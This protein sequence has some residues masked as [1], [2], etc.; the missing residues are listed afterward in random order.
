MLIKLLEIFINFPIDE[1][2]IHYYKQD[3]EVFLLFLIVIFFI[4]TCFILFIFIRKKT[5]EN[6]NFKRNSF[7]IFMVT[8]FCL[9][10]FFFN[11]IEKKMNSNIEMCKEGILKQY[12]EM[13]TI[14]DSKLDDERI[15][16]KYYINSYT[17]DAYFQI[18]FIILGAIFYKTL[19]LIAF[20]FRNNFFIPVILVLFSNFLFFVT[21]FLLYLY[22]ANFYFKGELRSDLK[23]VINAGLQ[24][25]YVFF[26]LF[27]IFSIIYFI[28]FVLPKFSESCTLFQQALLNNKG[29]E[30]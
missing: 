2:V 7:V 22:Y 27:F 20:L 1:T 23:I 17:P 18:L 11:S 25:M 16:Q 29:A 3:L 30:I 12:K 9:V 6:E 5:V 10:L 19:K 26:E 8:T 15:L 14:D 13:Q 24:M 4:D 28:F 21:K